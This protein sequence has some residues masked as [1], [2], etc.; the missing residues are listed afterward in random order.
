MNLVSIDNRAFSSND[1]LT[2]I[3]IPASVLALGDGAFSWCRNLIS[4]IV[5]GSL[6]TFNRWGV[7]DFHNDGLVISGLTGSTA[8][9]HA[10]EEGIPFTAIT[11]DQ[12]VDDDK[13]SCAECKTTNTGGKFC[14]EC[15]T[16]RPTAPKCTICGFVPLEGSRPKFCPECGTEFE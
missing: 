8:E 13:W 6:T 16:A 14:T 3:T 2:Q 10:K 15:G 7:F 5:E 4:V 11:I 1:N 12:T 9:A